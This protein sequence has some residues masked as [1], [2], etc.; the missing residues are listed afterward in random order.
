MSD[1]RVLSRSSDN[2]WH[3]RG[4]DDALK[5]CRTQYEKVRDRHGHEAAMNYAVGYRNGKRRR[6]EISA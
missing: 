3:R 1:P 2:I 5:A 4:Y 6:E